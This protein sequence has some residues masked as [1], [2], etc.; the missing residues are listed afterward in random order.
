[1]VPVMAAMFGLVID[2]ALVFGGRS[3]I[4]RVVQ[5]VNRAVSIGLIRDLD[6][7]QERVMN[8]IVSF[9]PEA[10]AETTVDGGVISTVVTLPMS[11]LTATGFVTAFKDFTVIVSA[12]H[13]AEN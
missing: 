4:L 3:Q 1:M 8:S 7:A 9:A 13:L 5:D 6:E 2:T 10:V 12:Q 11:D